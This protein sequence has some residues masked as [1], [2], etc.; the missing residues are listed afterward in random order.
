MIELAKR[1]SACVEAARAAAKQTADQ[2]K[3]INRYRD[4]AAKLCE[5]PLSYARPDQWH[6]YIPPAYD[7]ETEGGVT[8]LNTS[9][10]RAALLALLEE[11]A[12]RADAERGGA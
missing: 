9:P 3:L 2:H 1:N 5:P 11:A 7:A 4:I 10:R 6:G 8:R 12:E